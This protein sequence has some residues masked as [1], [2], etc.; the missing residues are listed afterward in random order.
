MKV[1]ELVDYIDWDNG[2]IIAIKT[3]NDSIH[4]VAAS[5]EDFDEKGFLRKGKYILF[6]AID[7]K[8]IK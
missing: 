1:K 6:R 7:T 5:T 3:D 8:E 2:D 4:G